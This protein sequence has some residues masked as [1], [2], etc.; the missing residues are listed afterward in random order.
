MA[1]WVVIG[2]ACGFTTAGRQV[3][4][5]DANWR[6]AR[7]SHP[8]AAKADFDDSTWRLVRLPHDWA[9][10]GPFD[11]SASNGRTGKLPWRG[12]GWY[13]KVFTLR[14]AVS[15]RR[16]I[17]LFDGVM[18]HP[19]VYVNGA[20][21]GSWVYGYNAFWLDVTEH[22]RFGGKN[23]V[24]VHVD[25]WKHASRWY[26]GAGI[27]RKVTMLL[28]DPLH[29]PVWGV[30]VTTPV[31]RADGA[32]V[33]VRTTVANDTG[34]AADVTV[35]TTIIDAG[36]E[37][38]ARAST[39]IRSQP[40][41]SSQ[42]DQSLAV[43]RPRLW[44]VDS[45]QLYT[46]RTE[47]MSGGRL[48]DETETTFGIR[49]IE[50]TADDGLHINGRRVQLKGVDLH[51]DYGPLGAAALPAA[52]RRRLAILKDMGANAIRTSH[53]PRSTEFMNLCDRMGFVVFDE[54]FD[55]WGST[56][57]YHVGA[58]DFV[59]DCAEREIRNFVLRDRNHPCVVAWSIGNE[60]SW[61]EVN[62]QG[63]TAGMVTA[64][65]G[66]FKKYDPTR[67][68]T[69]GCLV[70]GAARPENHALDALD[71]T[72]WNYGRKYLNAKRCWPDKPIIYS[73]SASALSTRGF[74]ELPHPREK[75][76]YSSRHQVDSYD[77]NS[78]S[79]PRDIPDWDF[80]RMEVDRYVAGEFVWTGFDYIGEPTPFAKEARSS[81]FGIIDLCGMPKDRYWLYRSHWRP[82]AATVHILPHWNWPGRIGKPVPVYVYTNG[83]EAELFLNG[84]SLGRRKKKDCQPD[85]A[86]RSAVHAG[87]RLADPPAENPYYE[88]IDR[89]RLRWENVTYQPG[90][91]RA[92]AYLAG[93]RIG[94][95]EVR[96][97]GPPA[98]IRLSPDRRSIQA[99]GDDLCYILVEAVDGRG[100]PC[101]LAD[102]LVHF[103]VQ[104]PATIAGIG[105]G[106]P[107]GMEPF[108]A[109]QH[110]L[111]YGKA[112]LILRSIEGAGGTISVTA[113][114][115]KLTPATVALTT[116]PP[117]AGQ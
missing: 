14:P 71:I 62:R 40:G 89:Y 98:R 110:R 85:P 46:A 81:Y 106:N 9:I 101:P 86:G 20:V 8:D 6:F 25:T 23:V 21:A 55:K 30:Y 82:Q 2:Q 33:R 54:A 111:F 7:G 11:A 56:A 57:G 26:P 53:N 90:E 114:S 79:G 77:L 65:A 109:S 99:D 87:H 13:R 31:V 88:V 60:M 18:A 64:M 24:A 70:N 22:V 1:A 10:A 68:V 35:R 116:R 41:K 66:F 76:E 105:N 44:N 19:T 12:E 3:V 112:M 72:S 37:P 38:V 69:M 102:N 63:E 50:W 67:P 42:A 113:E 48:R 36:G 43:A 15:P 51:H 61:I 5:F 78:A 4:N 39:S 91:L 108:H 117:T 58:A 115:E 92:V 97:A 16:V 29:V 104:G 103:R 52:I 83:D 45:P 27:Y 84:K 94:Q 73:E 59:R 34:R 49:S 95:A 80:Y 47:L 107:L 17:L 28:V 75:T 96:T 93:K 32:T 74:Y 100:T